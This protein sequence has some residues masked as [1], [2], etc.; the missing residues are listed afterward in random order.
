MPLSNE[1]SDDNQMAAAQPYG[2]LI[3]KVLLETHCRA[4]QFHLRRTG[5]FHTYGFHIAFTECQY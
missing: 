3:P 2:Y 1:A 4:C 5:Q